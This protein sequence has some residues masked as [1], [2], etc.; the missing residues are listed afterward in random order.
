MA[1]GSIFG[2]ASGV[3]DGFTAESPDEI[4]DQQI[5]LRQLMP[6]MTQKKLADDVYGRL[7][8][9]AVN[10][11]ILITDDELEE[12]DGADNYHTLLKVTLLNSRF[13]I[14]GLRRE[15]ICLRMLAKAT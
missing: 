5:T 6:P 9:A 8:D 12:V 14:S 4:K 11:P 7:A 1:A 2:A 10:M 13:A 15:P 3:Y